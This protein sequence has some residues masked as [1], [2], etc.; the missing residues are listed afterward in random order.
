MMTMAI[1]YNCVHKEVEKAKLK[2]KLN[3]QQ[4]VFTEKPKRTRNS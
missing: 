1:N 3:D 2:N 4:I